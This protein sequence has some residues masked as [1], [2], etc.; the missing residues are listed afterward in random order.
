[1]GA[2]LGMQAQKAG[3]CQQMG[4]SY[5]TPTGAQRLRKA[6][7]CVGLPGSE[8]LIGRLKAVCGA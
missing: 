2:G 3:T 4:F 6:E 7:K 8:R 5:R 1:M